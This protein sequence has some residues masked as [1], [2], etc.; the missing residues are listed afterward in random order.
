MNNLA[1]S[2]GNN[3]YNSAVN[4]TFNI[5]NNVWLSDLSG[6]V[7]PSTNNYD[8]LSTSPAMNAGSAIPAFADNLGNV[9]TVSTDYLSR[10][11]IVGTR[12]DAGAYEHP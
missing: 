4:S 8:L 12:M 3:L 10:P 9:F 11:R 7:S 6:F 5:H 1:Y 2:A